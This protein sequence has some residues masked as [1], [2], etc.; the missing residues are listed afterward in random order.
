VRA[1]R[2][3]GDYFD[4]A[5]PEGEA[6]AEAMRAYGEFRKSIPESTWPVLESMTPIPGGMVR[7]GGTNREIRV[8]PFSLAQRTVTRAEFD[9]FLKAT[10]YGARQ[11]DPV[12][13][14]DCSTALTDAPEAVNDPPG[15]EPAVCVT[16]TEADAYVAWLSES[17][18]LR[19]RLPSAVEWEHAASIPA[20]IEDLAGHQ[21]EWVGD[22]AVKSSGASDR[23]DT[24]SKRIAMRTGAVGESARLPGD[25][26]G[27]RSDGYRANDLAF[28][29]ALGS[30]APD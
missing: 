1:E 25:A 7:A 29:V 24:C 16:W 2:A 11:S 9:A 6:F 30:L 14:D 10:G 15:S 12:S 26:R 20:V 3:F 13:A 18:G 21:W 23:A 19:F 27:I 17:S 28:R 8:A 4:V 22:C 5:S